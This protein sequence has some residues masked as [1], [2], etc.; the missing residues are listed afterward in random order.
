M[1][2][3]LLLLAFLGVASWAG[4][5]DVRKDTA[6]L[7]DLHVG[8]GTELGDE[9]YT[10]NKDQLF[11]A[12]RAPGLEI[13]ALRDATGFSLE[14]ANVGGRAVY[15]AW[16]E[17]RFRVSPLITMGADMKYADNA[18]GW[19]WD[20]DARAVLSLDLARVSGHPLYVDFRAGQANFEGEADRYIS[21]ALMFGLKREKL[22]PQSMF[23]K[24]AGR[25]KK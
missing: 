2:R 13:P 3:I 18:A 16:I 22:P 10:F 25:K 14:V 5:Q 24:T 23:G 12:I 6:F 19:K 8:F 21:V 11:L 15:S 1:K 7:L 17:N 4:A 20:F 9:A